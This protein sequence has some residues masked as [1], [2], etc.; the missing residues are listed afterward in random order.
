MR[1]AQ[2]HAVNAAYTRVHCV[3]F[4]LISSHLSLSLS[5]SL[6]CLLLWV[7]ALDEDRAVNISYE[8]LE[9]TR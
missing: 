6:S 9:G 1:V 2:L 4:H 3:S 7:S 5:L 8:I